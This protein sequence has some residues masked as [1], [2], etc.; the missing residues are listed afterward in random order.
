MRL[1][2]SIPGT[3]ISYIKYFGHKRRG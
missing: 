1:T 2:F 3:G